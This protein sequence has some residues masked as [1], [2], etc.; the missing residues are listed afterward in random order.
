MKTSVT[1]IIGIVFILILY[2][3]IRGAKKYFS[4]L[5]DDFSESENNISIQEMLTNFMYVIILGVILLIV[6]TVIAGA[7]P[8]I[9]FGAADTGAVP[10]DRFSAQNLK[11]MALLAATRA[12]YLMTNFSTVIIGV[13]IVIAL[14]AWA[15]DKMTLDKKNCEAMN[16][17][18]KDFP[19]IASISGG[20]GYDKTFNLKDYY[21]K[22]AYNCCCA[23]N[24]KND[25][26]NI[27]ALKRLH[28]TGGKMLRFRNILCQ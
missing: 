17:L 10:Q 23:G 26:V 7:F 27:C 9:T 4:S 28:Q 24:Y 8:N 13:L 25:F 11:R 16:E 18:Y 6:I 22:S 20:T 15:L 5:T 2:L 19:P 14:V 3:L 12:K 1:I 21:I